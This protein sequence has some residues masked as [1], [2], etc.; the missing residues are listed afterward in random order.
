MRDGK[1]RISINVALRQLLPSCVAGE[2]ANPSLRVSAW[3]AGLM[4]GRRTERARLLLRLKGGLSARFLMK[5]SEHVNKIR[6][7]APCWLILPCT[8]PD[9]KA[10]V[11]PRKPSAGAVNRMT[12]G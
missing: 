7:C 6:F 8:F 4:E 5:S 1:G 2:E 3:R 10:K 12:R 11:E 9:G